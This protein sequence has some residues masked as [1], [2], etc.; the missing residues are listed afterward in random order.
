VQPKVVT[1]DIVTGA[2]KFAVAI[3]NVED[4]TTAISNSAYLFLVKIME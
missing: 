3:N 1:D 2:S 4:L